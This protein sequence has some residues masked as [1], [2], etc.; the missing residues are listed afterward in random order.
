MIMNKLIPLIAI[1]LLLSSVKIRAAAQDADTDA[2]P[3]Q[4]GDAIE[5][6]P[7]TEQFVPRAADSKWFHGGLLLLRPDATVP[8]DRIRL[9]NICRWAPSDAALFEP[10]GD[11]TIARFSGS[12]LYARVTL[13]D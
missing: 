10:V 4:T 11:L 12:H 6:M 5:P 7:A 3:A 2:I 9:K 13:E 1:A 8:D